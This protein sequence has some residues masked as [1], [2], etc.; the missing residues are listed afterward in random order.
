MSVEDHP[1][2]ATGV[3]RVPAVVPLPPL[4]R[5]AAGEY[6]TFR[7]GNE[8]YAIDILK[9]QEIRS[10]DAITAIPNAPSFIKGVTNLRGII[11]PIVDLRLKFN[12]GAARYDA[13]TVVIILNI[14]K[15]VVGIVV[16]SVSD[17]LTLTGEQIKPVPEFATTLD[18][19]YIR[20]M[21]PVDEQM[22][23]LVDIELL[24]TG[25]DMALVDR[26]VH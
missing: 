9:V 1:F 12:V 21:G 24:M 22:L 4:A 14:A 11:V 2:E 7:L 5:A 26:A 8:D 23:I 16:D 20:G 6:L 13:S 10:Y 15:R 19:A 17:V 18:T 3:A 25:T